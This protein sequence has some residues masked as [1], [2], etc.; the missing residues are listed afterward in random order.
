MWKTIRTTLVGAVLACAATALEARADTAAPASDEETTPDEQATPEDERYRVPEPEYV[1]VDLS[2]VPTSN[3]IAAKLPQ[4]LRLTPSNVG[5]V[6]AALLREQAAFN[7][8]DA[9]R[10]VSSINVQSNGGVHDF[11]LIRGFD[12]L[13]GSLVLTDG[14]AEPEA[15]HYPMYNIEGV[16][17][18]KG[19]AGFLYGNDPL[20]GVVNLVRKQPLPTDSLEIGGL[21]GS[22]GTGQATVDWNL[23]D[24][25]GQQRFRLNGLYYES[26]GYRDQTDRQHAAI[27]PGYALRLGERSTLNF[28]LEYVDAE[29]RPDSGVPIVDGAL[30]DVPRRRSY[31]TPFDFSDQEIARFQVDYETRLSDVVTLR[32]KLYV[33]D[34]DWDARGTLFGGAVPDGTGSYEVIRFQTTLVDAQQ[35]LGNQLEALIET[36]TG[37]LHHSLLAGL[38]V[39]HLSD[40]FDIGIV[41]PSDPAMPFVPGIPTIDLFDP[42]ETAVQLDP[43]PFLVGESRSLVVA[44]Y[45]V[46]Q[47]E[48]SPEVRVSLGARYDWT[49]R[50]DERTATNPP[51]AESVSR[52]DGDLS[53]MLGV[54][55]TPTASLSLY[56]NA[57]ESFAP[58]GVRVFGELDPEE[59]RGYEVGAK[60]TF[61]DDAIRT[62]FSLYQIDRENVAIP[63]DN[64][65]T[66]QA[67]DQRSRGFEI[68]LAAEPR[69]RLRTF[70]T[71]AYTD[72]ELVRFTERTIVGFD[73][74]TGQPIYGTV[75]RSGNTPAFVPEHL[76]S[77]WVSQGFA[78]GFGVGGGVRWFTDQFIAEDNQTEIDGALV[79]DATVSY[80][81]RHCRL[82]LHLK[83][84]TDEEYEVRGFGSTSVI[85]ADPFTA[86]VGFEFRP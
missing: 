86:W 71:Y 45:V 14:A 82:A 11:F 9:L 68:E 60:K 66:Q 32:D 53:P 2:Y 3:T 57:A 44:P 56:G 24:R 50:D 43:F 23:A 55:Y 51:L 22:Y 29:Y 31:Q 33:R 49:S 67:G 70:L 17:V 36:N 37:A 46:D 75:D 69:L 20:A 81:F 48:L 41:P 52:D 27:N 63:D 61:L 62:T 47:L 12:S 54:V 1:E 19:P 58:A 38:E 64:G 83:N 40:D 84:L 34:V 78:G 59:S 79:L 25:E 39:K 30:P 13:S 77:A 28:N 76:L 72:A 15:T 74:G 21:L 5:S 6:S 8:G 7:L 85:P 35:F 26:N 16:E 10:N 4:E 80:D 65:V 18:L 73:P 42:V